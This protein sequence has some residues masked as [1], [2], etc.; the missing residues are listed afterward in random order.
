MNKL[1]KVLLLSSLCVLTLQITQAQAADSYVDALSSEATNT[2]MKSSQ[3]AA[4]D[5]DPEPAV[6]PS[7]SEDTDA[8]ADKVGS[9]LEKIL[10]GSSS[11]DVK[12]EDLANIVSGA[13]KEG[14]EIDAIQDAVSAAMSDLQKKEGINIKPEVFE[15]AA[16]AVTDIVNSSKDVAQGD[17]NDPYIQSLNAEVDETSLKDHEGKDEKPEKAEEK[18]AEASTE[19]PEEKTAEAEAS[20]ET[21][22]Q[23][24]EED[25]TD[26]ADAKTPATETE[27]QTASSASAGNNSAGRTIVVLKGESLSKI[28]AKIYGSGRKYYLL[29]EANKDTISNPNSIA[30]GQVLK[31]PPL[32]SE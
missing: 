32:P 30:V 10:S 5:D 6:T 16:K 23:K 7:G 28:A 31:V 21:T 2:K 26:T 15:F 13:V 8:L 22:E 4:T 3:T 29:Y 12:K 9:Q 20:T 19:K 14:H 17:P 27:T 18:T 24:A 1:P 11:G 25:K